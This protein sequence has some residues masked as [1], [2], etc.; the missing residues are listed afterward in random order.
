M[1]TTGVIQKLGQM[2]DAS[3]ESLAHD[4]LVRMI[5]E[6]DERFQQMYRDL[7]EVTHLS[8]VKSAI[9]LYGVTPSIYENNKGYL[10]DTY[11]IDLD[12]FLN[13]S[14]EQLTYCLESIGSTIRDLLIRIQKT[15]I[16][17]M[18]WFTTESIFKTYVSNIQF[19]KIRMVEMK[20]HIG[21]YDRHAFDAQIISGYD[22]LTYNRLISA[23]TAMAKA[24]NN[25]K[26]PSDITELANVKMDVLEQHLQKCGFR[27]NAATRSIQATDTIFYRRDTA[28]AMEWS[29]DKVM[30]VY[31]EVLHLVQDGTDIQRLKYALARGVN[32]WS[33]K[34]NDILKADTV[35][36]QALDDA[37]TMKGGCLLLQH[38]TRVVM[39]QTS[40]LAAQWC[41]M[42]RL[43]GA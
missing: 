30:K 9:E 4:N 26:V 5:D 23:D 43:L 2:Q 19:Y 21:L 22:Y 40:G 17:V 16:R 10:W 18:E 41:Q 3:I 42:A 28:R 35:D 24:L 6:W 27:I 11:E 7:D 14:N 36:K 12:P 34:I 38:L 31:H 15:L 20:S 29:A 37:T 1:T 8:D 33:K 13:G 39:Q 25:I 32:E